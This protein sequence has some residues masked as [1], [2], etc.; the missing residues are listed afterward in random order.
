MKII[1]DALKEI[2]KYSLAFVIVIAIFIV[3]LIVSSL[4]P[5]DWIQTNS[6]E[7]TA[8]LA[9]EGNPN[10]V[11]NIKLDNY[12]DALMVNTAYSIDPSRPLES[13]LLARKNYVPEREQAVYQDKNGGLA[14]AFEANLDIMK[15]LEMTVNHTINTSFEYARYWHG[16]LVL[17]RPALVFW[18]ISEIKIFIGMCLTI[19]AFWLFYLLNKKGVLKYGVLIIFALLVTDYFLMGLTLQGV[20]TFIISVITSV[21]IV[22][23][24]E[25]IKRI[26][27]YFFIT[28]MVTCFF[29]LLTH[30]I[31]TLGLPLLI[32]LLLKQKIENITLKEALKIIVCNTILWGIG[33][34]GAHLAKWLL[35][36]VLYQ[37]EI[38]SKSVQQF[39]FRSQGGSEEAD[40]FAGLTANLSYAAQRTILYMVPVFLYT[41]VSL[42]RNYKEIQINWK[43]GLPYL[44]V[45]IM[46][47]VWYAVMKNHS[48]NHA[49]FTWRGFVV[50][51]AG[52]GIFL[53]KLLERKTERKE[54]NGKTSIN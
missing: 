25:K 20:M 35:V 53:V 13:A 28:G 24:F 30:P 10:Y 32:Y 48:I 12:T 43:A 4:F 36:D 27:L 22:L 26:G 21:L 8:I 41:L 23:R 49:Y 52:I 54:N 44:I 15:E 34:A 33:Y 3:T 16:Y 2:M 6:E 17:L 40:W 9:K 19:L 18:N 38:L 47:C 50:F 39:L 7:S 42:V 51:Y 46:P 45:A 5:R 31:I 37:R 1:R 11:L 29:D 14:S